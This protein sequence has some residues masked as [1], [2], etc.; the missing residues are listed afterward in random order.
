MPL[1]TLNTNA[2][3]DNQ[4]DS[5]VCLALSQ[6]ASLSIEKPEPKIRVVINSGQTM[7]FGGSFDPCAHLKIISIGHVD[8]ERN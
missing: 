7:S 4:R 3:K 6:H 5:N 2:V 8:A 1:L